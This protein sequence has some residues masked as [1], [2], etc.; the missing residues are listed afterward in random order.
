MSAV[1]PSLDP[2]VRESQ[3]S[4][5]LKSVEQNINELERTVSGSNRVS[6]VF[7]EVLQ[8]DID[9]LR[10][11][12]TAKKLDR[13]GREFKTLDELNTKLGHLAA[14]YAAK[15]HVSIPGCEDPVTVP[16]ARPLT[17]VQNAFADDEVVPEDKA[18]LVGCS[19]IRIRGEGHCFF[20]AVAAH[21]FTDEHL[22]ALE[23][24]LE[25][26]RPMVPHTLDLD[27][28]IA[29]SHRRVDGGESV[30]HMLCDANFSDRWVLALRNI[31]AQWWK[32]LLQKSPRTAQEEAS[33]SAFLAVTRSSQ[34]AAEGRR[35]SSRYG[36]I[37]QRHGLFRVKKMGRARRSDCS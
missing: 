10:A 29:E 30:D 13:N 22:H 9:L 7:F 25:I 15:Y 6:V 32:N 35:R 14:Q 21:L 3:N 26:L 1:S 11:E 2:W 23:S 8:K 12:Y 24:R 16:L 34:G 31:G 18:A 27:E 37:C 36:P 4:N 33:L 28:L 19:A 20:R 5:F 17:N